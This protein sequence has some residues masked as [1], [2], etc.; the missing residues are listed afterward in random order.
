MLSRRNYKNYKAA[1][2]TIEVSLAMALGIVVLFL[3]IGIFSDNLK[4]MV[5]ASGIQHLLNNDAQATKVGG[6][7]NTKPLTV[8]ND[9]TQSQ[10]NVQVV[11]DQGLTLGQ[12]IA[13]AQAS[14]NKYLTT[15]P[16]N[17]AQM[18]DLAKALTILSVNAG[19]TSNIYPDLRR[20]YVSISLNNGA[21]GTTTVKSSGKVINY[22]YSQSNSTDTAKLSVVKD[23]MGKSFS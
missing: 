19:T 3:A 1:G 4:A 21:V 5:A 14:I 13:N 10:D 17:E 9:P 18:E 22:T 12:Y 6:W 16:T 8:A 2:V 11:A 20:Q 7:G 23:V 15:P